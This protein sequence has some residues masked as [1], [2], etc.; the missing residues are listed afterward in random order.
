M[1]L[2]TSNGNYFTTFQQPNLLLA[3]FFHDGVRV[4]RYADPNETTFILNDWGATAEDVENDPEVIFGWKYDTDEAGYVTGTAQ[5]FI[6][7][8]A[9]CEFKWLGYNDDYGFFNAQYSEI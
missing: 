8:P 3:G 7:I 1:A 2:V 4:L 5:N 9:L 6:E